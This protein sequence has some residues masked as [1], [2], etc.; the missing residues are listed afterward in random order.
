MSDA[1]GNPISTRLPNLSRQILSIG[2]GLAA[3]WLIF[4]GLSRVRYTP[5]TESPPPMDDLR[6]I[7]LPLEAPPPIVRPQEV[8]TVTMS[9]LI[10]LAP[11]RSESMLKLPAVPI[12][13]ETVPPVM[14]VPK[15]DF[16]PKAFKPTDI[17][18]EFETRHVFQAR[19]VDQR[20]AAL[21][22]V[23]PEVSRLML[24]AAKRLR[25]GCIAIVNRDGTVE[26]I[27]LTDSSGN[28]DLD[29]ASLEA[30]KGWRFSPALRRGRAVRQ[31]VQQSFL[32]KVEKG[33]PLE[34]Y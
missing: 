4:Y 26:S 25:V 27:R 17:N 34:I 33:S 16:S 9:N 18:S 19:E 29:E 14:G 28:N 32:Y 7:E 21:V 15:I 22:K 5:D 10:V 1:A 11:E 24:R 6:T 31:W 2:I 30:F 3:S 8:P 13:A 20:C 12:L 23:R